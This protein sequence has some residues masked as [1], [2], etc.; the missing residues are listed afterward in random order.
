MGIPDAVQLATKDRLA[1]ETLATVAPG[2]R[3]SDP[4]SGPESG[5]PQQAKPAVCGAPRAP[6]RGIRGP[7]PR[8]SE[9]MRSQASRSVRSSATRSLPRAE[10]TV[11]RG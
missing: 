8:P 10:N 2:I 3:W 7:G 6:T 4:E 11:R 1:R 5:F 9:S